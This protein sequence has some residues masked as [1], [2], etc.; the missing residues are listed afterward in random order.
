MPYVFLAKSYSEVWSWYRVVN[1]TVAQLP[2][3]LCAFSH[4]IGWLVHRQAGLDPGQPA[5]AGPTWWAWSRWHLLPEP[6]TALRLPTYH[7]WLPTSSRNSSWVRS[8]RAARKHSVTL[9]MC[10]LAQGMSVRQ[11]ARSPPEGSLS[12]KTCP[13]NYLL[14]KTCQ[15]TDFNKIWFWRL[16]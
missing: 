3:C 16:S 1:N 12:W 10:L 11:P 9:Q 7:L 6:C 13:K 8:Q 15:E 5:G 2:S 14:W 4:F